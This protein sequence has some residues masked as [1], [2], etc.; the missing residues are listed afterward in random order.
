MKEETKNLPP[1]RHAAAT[2][3][4]RRAVIHPVEQAVISELLTVHRLAEQPTKVRVV[5]ALLER[6]PLHVPEVVEELTRKILVELME[7]RALLTLADLLVLL[8]LGARAQ[9]LPRQLT[10]RQVHEHVTERL[11]VIAATLLEPAVGVDAR[12]ARRAGQ[13]LPLAVRDVLVRVVVA[14]TLSEP[15]VD[16]EEN[17][18]LVPVAHE[19]VVR[20]EVAMDERLPVDELHAAECLQ[21]DHQ[22][23]LERHATTALREAVLQ[24]GSEAVHD[25]HVVVRVGAVVATAGHA[26]NRPG[27]RRVQPLVDLVLVVQLRVLHVGLLELDGDNLAILDVGGE[28]DLA[29]RAGAELRAQTPAAADELLR[30]ERHGR[31][32]GGRGSVRALRA[33]R[34]A[35]V[36][37]CAGGACPARAVVPPGE[38][39][40]AGHADVVR[41]EFEGGWRRCTGRA[42]GRRFGPATRRG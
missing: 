29:E 41:Y 35:G 30:P 16:D 32:G 7:T 38:D 42:V 3:T 18:A 1:S 25:E 17:T 13:V 40:S 19:D 36:M 9:P 15:I 37:V 33:V 2:C 22:H 21:P 23:R 11:E 26:D 5:R 14:V 28:K 20:L 8:L 34:K 12:V 6:E 4:Q 39:A 31:R 27:T 10:L 24:R